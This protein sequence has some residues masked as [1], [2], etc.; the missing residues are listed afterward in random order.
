MNAGLFYTS[1]FQGLFVKNPEKIRTLSFMNRSHIYLSQAIYYFI[2]GLWPVV[3]ISS[4][5]SVT[6]PKTDVWLVKMVGL[7][8]A[9]IAITLFSS[10]KK[11]SSTTKVLSITSALAYLSIDVFYYFNGTL[12]AVYLADAGIELLIILLVL[13]GK[14]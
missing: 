12:S 2:T 3:H 4:F 9:A 7:L 6:G 11:S 5:M 13:T 14:K 1:G 10:Y 8:T